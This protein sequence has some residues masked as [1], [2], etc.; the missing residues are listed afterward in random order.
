MKLGVVVSPAAGWTYDELRVLAN[1][2]ERVGFE[3]FWVSAAST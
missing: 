2:A 1:E 3:S